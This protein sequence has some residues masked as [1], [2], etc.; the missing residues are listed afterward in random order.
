MKLKLLSFLLLFS[1][2]INYALNTFKIS[3]NYSVIFNLPIT[4]ATLTTTVSSTYTSAQLGGN[5]TSDGGATVTERGV[6]YSLT[7]NPTT[8]NTKVVI[9]SGTGAFSQ[10]VTGLTTST[11]YYVRAYAI[12]S[13]GTSY[14]SELSFTTA[15]FLWRKYYWFRLWNKSNFG[16]G[17]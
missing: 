5:I 3:N 4:T 11:T 2:N 1:V 6:V 8:A 17:S 16:N 7:T 12:N 10:A 15:A 9:G 14:G 13:Q